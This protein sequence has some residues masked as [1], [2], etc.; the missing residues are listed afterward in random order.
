MVFCR[1]IYVDEAKEIATAMRRVHH[2]RKLSHQQV[3][4]PET[5]KKLGQIQSAHDQSRTT[6]SATASAESRREES[7]AVY[8]AKEMKLRDFQQRFTEHIKKEHFINHR[9][10]NYNREVGRKA[11]VNQVSLCG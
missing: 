8:Q 2:S 11:V 5:V 3:Y 1:K 7:S 10:R 6:R 4:Y 9:K